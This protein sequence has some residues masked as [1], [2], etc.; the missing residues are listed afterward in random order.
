MSIDDDEYDLDDEVLDEAFEE[1]LEEGL[2]DFDEEDEGM[3]FDEDEVLFDDDEQEEIDREE[4]LL[5]AEKKKINIDIGFDKIAIIGAVIVGLI[6]VVY[7]VTTKTAEQRVEVFQSALT[8][9]GASDGEVFG[10]TQSKNIAT[11]SPEKQ[12]EQ[13]AFLYKPEGLDAL[14][15]NLRDGKI[16]EDT[17]IRPLTEEEKKKS[18]INSAEFI[19]AASENK[20]PEPEGVFVSAVTGEKIEPQIS[21]V[22]QD[23][24]VDEKVVRTPPAQEQPIKLDGVAVLPSIDAEKIEQTRENVNEYK[25]ELNFVP[26]DQVAVK[27]SPKEQQQIREQVVPKRDPVREPVASSQKKQSALQVQTEAAVDEEKM[28]SQAELLALKKEI[29]RLK[30]EKVALEQQ[31]ALR[32]AENNKTMVEEVKKEVAPPKVADKAV[33][34]QLVEKKVASVA[35]KKKVVK[36]KSSSSAVPTL[37]N[38]QLRAAQPGKAWISLRGKRDMLSVAVGDNVR[39]LGRVVAIS[40]QGGRWVVIGTEG[41]IEQ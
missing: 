9:K 37:S 36:K 41:Q 27:L 30:N 22:D 19:V 21:T 33:Q 34:S 11:V 10:E 23:S 26:I 32:Q 12:E 16:I 13:K 39:D 18:E 6:V 31:A 38:W 20:I 25:K 14:P 17:E 3:S 1:D 2:E 24:V 40:N 8:M 29:E 4:A 15:N 5:G 7:Q 35:P 28:R